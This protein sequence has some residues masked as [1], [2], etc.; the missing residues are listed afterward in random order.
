MEI[1]FWNKK[2]SYHSFHSFRA[3]YAS[4]L[5]KKTKDPLLVSYTLGHSS[6]ETTKRYIYHD[7]SNFHSIINDTFT[8]SI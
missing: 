5:Y 1:N 4:Q 7:L 6:F 3:D 2:K 8:N